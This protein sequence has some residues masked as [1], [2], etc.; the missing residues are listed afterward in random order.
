MKKQIIKELV[1]ATAEEDCNFY[2][3]EG[4]SLEMLQREHDL[5]KVLGNQ[6]RKAVSDIVLGHNAAGMLIEMFKVYEDTVRT[7]MD[8]WCEEPLGAH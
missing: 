4:V 6:W 7:V 8:G 1:V 3:A 5:D 2:Y